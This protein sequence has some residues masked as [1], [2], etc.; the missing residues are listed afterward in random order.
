MKRDKREALAI[1]QSRL[2]KMKH[3]RTL[4]NTP[5]H[6]GAELLTT[7]R[8]RR[9]PSGRIIFAFLCIDHRVGDIS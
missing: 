9:C 6:C 4:N 7:T 8:F 2:I 1:D 5:Y 3:P